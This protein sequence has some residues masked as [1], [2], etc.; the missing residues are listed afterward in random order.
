MT[1]RSSQSCS[2]HYDCSSRGM[3]LIPQFR[4]HGSETLPWRLLT[5]I[6]TRCRSAVPRC[7]PPSTCPPY[8]LPRLSAVRLLLADPTVPKATEGTTHVVGGYS[9]SKYIN[10]F[11]FE[12]TQLLDL[13]FHFYYSVLK[14]ETGF[15][16]RQR[17]IYIEAEGNALLNKCMAF[18]SIV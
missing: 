7:W 15:S 2:Q 10:N 17:Q 8:K 9:D 6:V 11:S 18:W 5:T 13:G 4:P 1:Y 16:S 14:R 12:T 3:S